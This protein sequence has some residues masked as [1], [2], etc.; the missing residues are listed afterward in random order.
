MGRGAGRHLRR[1]RPLG[2][3]VFPLGRPRSGRRAGLLRLP[4]HAHPQADPR[5]AWVTLVH[6]HIQ[7]HPRL[8]GARRLRSL[9]PQGEALHLCLTAFQGLAQPGDLLAGGQGEDLGRGVCCLLGSRA[10]P[11]LPLQLLRQRPARPKHPT[12]PLVLPENGPLL[13]QVLLD[14]VGHLAAVVPFQAVG[15]LDG[16]FHEFGLLSGVPCRGGTRGGPCPRLAR[17]V[18]LLR[19]KGLRALLRRLCRCLRRCLQRTPPR[20]HV[21]K[22]QGQQ[23]VRTPARPGQGARG[24]GGAGGGRLRPVASGYD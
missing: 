8:L 7:G 13:F 12:E 18:D 20:R 3:L 24:E 5:V 9:Q 6:F 14:E 19:E 10:R 1:S 21:H 11:R 22:A 2:L 23:P 15:C 4:R 16:Q 17:A